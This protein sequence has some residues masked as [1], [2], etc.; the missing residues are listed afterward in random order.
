MN[1]EFMKFLMKWRCTIL[2]ISLV[3]FLGIFPFLK[4]TP[5]GDAASALTVSMVILTAT[6][7]A[8][9]NGKHFAIVLFL[10]VLALL[11]E[12]VALGEKSSALTFWS[13]VSNIVLWVYVIVLLMKYVLE[14]GP[15]T[16]DEIA[17]AISVYFLL[18]IVWSIAHTSLERY[19]PGSYSN[20]DIVESLR[21][22]MLYFSFVT[23]TTLGYGDIVP[24]DPRSQ[25]LA[26]LE[27]TTG[28]LFLT[29]LVARL[30]GEYGQMRAEA[31]KNR[32]P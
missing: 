30:V 20:V 11:L 24:L 4:M 32:R 17:G 31:H 1:G 2:L 15:V 7:A 28:V 3:G 22:D 12:W 8:L 19:A 6:I 9:G 13:D 23:L 5:H 25:M 27:A 16:A 10:A 29:V 26:I 18:A 14:P 21:M